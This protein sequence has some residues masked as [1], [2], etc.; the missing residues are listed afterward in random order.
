MTMNAGLNQPNCFTGNFV[1]E[2][3]YCFDLFSIVVSLG[4]FVRHY[5]QLE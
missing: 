3:G 2:N 4:Q 1:V 5:V